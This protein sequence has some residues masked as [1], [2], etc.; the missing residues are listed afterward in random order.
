MQEAGMAR[1]A[2]ELYYQALRKKP[3]YIEAMVG[4]RSAGQGV[5]DTWVGE[6]QKASMDGRRK[7]ALD[8]YDN[9][10]AY[11]QRMAKV[12]VDLIIPTAIVSDYEDHLDEHL[13]ELD[14]QGHQQLDA[15]D[16]AGAASTFKEI[17]HLDAEYGDA[18]A[19]LIVA[20]AEPEYR[21]GKAMLTEMR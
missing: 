7:D 18:K 6:F 5:V 20:Q 9:M 12:D 14:E 1:Q 17:I 2:A 10:T 3:S 15:E 16:F 11:T 8:L 21:N 13:I 19:L 4:L